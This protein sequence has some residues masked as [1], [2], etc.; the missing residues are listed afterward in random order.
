[1]LVG[2]ALAVI[3]P[4]G[5]RSLFLKPSGKLLLGNSIRQNIIFVHVKKQFI[6]SEHS[7]HAGHAVHEHGQGE[8]ISG[9][10]PHPSEELD[11]HGII[12]ISLVLGFLFM[13]LIDQ[14]S[15]SRNKGIATNSVGIQRTSMLQKVC[16][17]S[18][19]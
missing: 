5:V 9:A 10:A 3:I 4:E 8:V 17:Q 7:G 12:G 1:M 19:I 13:L 15:S 2:T 18:D 11:M 6:F 14:I 16:Y